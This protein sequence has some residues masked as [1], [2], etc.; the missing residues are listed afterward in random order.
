MRM[1]RLASISDQHVE[2]IVGQKIARFQSMQ[3]GQ[4]RGDSVLDR[5]GLTIHGGMTRT[6]ALWLEL[7]K[8]EATLALP[9][10]GATDA[11]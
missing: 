10:T 6:V 1:Q 9:L 4:H 8:A 2:R 11:R 3:V 5:F 7:T